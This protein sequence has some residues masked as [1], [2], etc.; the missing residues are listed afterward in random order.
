MQPTPWLLLLANNDDTHKL[1]PVV[2]PLC[3]SVP[4]PDP[5]CGS[6]L[7][8]HPTGRPGLVMAGTLGSGALG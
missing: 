8:T 6:C 4:S 5:A 1:C 7:P 2:F 3:P